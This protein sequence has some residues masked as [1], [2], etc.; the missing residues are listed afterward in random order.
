MLTELVNLY[1]KEPHY[2][3]AL[4]RLEAKR[5]CAVSG[6][7]EV[8]NA[9][10]TSMSSLSSAQPHLASRRLLERFV[11]AEEKRTSELPSSTNSLLRGSAPSGGL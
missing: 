5:L 2:L 7:G 9:K 4:G 1:P 6:P 8:A 10:S 3:Y 11:G